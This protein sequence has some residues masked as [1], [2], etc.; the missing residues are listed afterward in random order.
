MKR[1]ASIKVPT[2]LASCPVSSRFESE[3][4]EASNPSTSGKR[5]K[6]LSQRKRKQERSQLRALIAANP[7]V[8]DDLLLEL[9]SDHPKEVTANP[10]FQL[11]Q[12]DG[13][14]WWE[15]CNLRSLCSLALAAGQEAIP[16]LKAVLRSSFDDIYNNYSEMVS[17][18]RQETWCYQRRVEIPVNEL[19]GKPS[20]DVILDINLCAL[21]E[22]VHDPWLELGDSAVSFSSGWICSLLTSLRGECI[23]SLF[24]VFGQDYS[25]HLVVQDLVS[26]SVELSSTSEEVRIDG[27]SVIEGKTGRK[28][29]ETHVYYECNFDGEPE[30][31]FEPGVLH[32]AVSK[33]VGGDIEGV[34]RDSSDDLRDLET[35]W[36][37]EPVVLSPD[38]PEASWEAWLSAWMM[39]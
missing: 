37:W 2:C 13:V 14:D 35:L 19:D 33:H 17:V 10:R 31:R 21:M 39:S 38:I 26:E 5:L 4:I 20:F 22:G 27:L 15:N 16:S 25:E 23:E 8:D 6:Q 34:S 7:G 24:E 9:A 12:L 11:L 28:L 3:L 29:F 1:S 30:P 32:V 18:K 36:G